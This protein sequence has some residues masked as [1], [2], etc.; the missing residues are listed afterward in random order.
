VKFPQYTQFGLDGNIMLTDEL[1]SFHLANVRDGPQLWRL[2]DNLIYNIS[3]RSRLADFPLA[4]I[5][6]NGCNGA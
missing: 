6:S 5:I 1:N 2:Y 4:L 3:D